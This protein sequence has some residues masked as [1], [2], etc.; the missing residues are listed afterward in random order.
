M[1][2]KNFSAKSADSPKTACMVVQ[3]PYE[4]DIR[5]RRKAE[6]LVAAGYSVDAIA[7]R[8]SHS[9]AKTY[10]VQGVTVHTVSLGKRR[11]SVL[12]YIFE[13]VA[14]LLISSFML[15][16][17][18]RRRK[19]AFVDI[20]T[21]PDFLVFAAWYPKLKGAKVILDMHELTPE[22]VMSKYGVAEKNWF[23]RISAFLERVSMR[24]ADYVITI[25]EPVQQLFESRGLARDKSI[26]MMNAA[27]DRLFSGSAAD[28]Q[29]SPRAGACVMMY[30]GTLTRIYGLDIAIEAFSLV[31]K[32]IPDAVFWILGD[33]PEVGNLKK[34]AAELGV[35]AN[36]RF[37]GKV[38]PEEISVWLRQCDI[39]VLPTRRDVFLDYSFSNKLTEYILMDKAVI[40]SRL[41]TIQHY[42]SDKALSYFEPGNPSDLAKQLLRLARDEKL[43]R[44]QA[45]TA[46]KEYAPICWDVMKGR[47]MN[48]IR[49]FSDQS[50]AVVARPMPEG[51]SLINAQAEVRR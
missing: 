50:R 24:Y 11:G 12:R 13:Y 48:L 26:V 14:F 7:L 49:Q 25:N 46:K 38:K 28:T 9:P 22:F 33:G 35:A 45:E 15:I 1:C 2:M 23:V 19:Y 34:K 40:A 41:K 29:S 5:V 37:I 43:R 51:A 4:I 16:R 10:D 30:H 32:E 18:M 31:L 20:N 47:Y 3:N 42:F 44:S 39:G 17:L 6:A 27:D 36:V 21:L 8:S